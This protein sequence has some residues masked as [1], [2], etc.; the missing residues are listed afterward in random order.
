MPVMDEFREERE[1]LKHG[2]PKEKFSYF[3][4]YYKWHVIIAVAVLFFAGSLIT[5]I[6]M[7]KETAFYA[8]MVNG[9]ELES[10]PEYLQRFAEYAS[11]DLEKK[12][13]LF[14][15]SVRINTDPA[16]Y[17]NPDSR[18]SSEKLMVYVASGE[19]D[20]FVTE[21]DIIEIYAYNEFFWDLRTMLTPE[22]I[23]K[24]GQQFYYVDQA[25]IHEQKAAQDALDYEYVPVYPDPLKPET[26]QDPVPVGIYLGNASPLR[27]SYFYAGDKIV[28]SVVA[29]CKRPELAAQFIDFLLQ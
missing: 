17:Y 20:V 1:A 5:Q 9:T 4:D 6:L 18:A 12:E 24:Y 15:T 2:T 27:E 19:V 28:V 13:I 14:D 29:N 21:P 7:R 3:M 8:A 11:I 25:I 23:E 16:D 10:A 26:M 22:Q